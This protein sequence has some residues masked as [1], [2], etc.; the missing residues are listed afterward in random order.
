MMQTYFFIVYAPKLLYYLLPIYYHYMQI[1]IKKPVTRLAHG[2]P[3]SALCLPS[4][5]KDPARGWALNR[6]SA[7]ASAQA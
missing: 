7:P 1:K 2:L 3:E 6:S 5:L 4:R